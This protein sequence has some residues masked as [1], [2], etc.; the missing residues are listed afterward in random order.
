MPIEMV[1]IGILS[2]LLGLLYKK[3]EES[4]QSIRFGRFFY[5]EANR[6]M[7]KPPMIEIIPDEEWFVS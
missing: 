4:S 2:Y 5:G 1:I 6:K 7:P 3:E